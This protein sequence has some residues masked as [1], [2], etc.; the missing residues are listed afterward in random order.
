MRAIVLV[1][2]AWVTPARALVCPPGTHVE[3]EHHEVLDGDSYDEQSCRRA[4]STKDGPAEIVGKAAGSYYNGKRDGVWTWSSDHRVARTVEYR[5]GHAHGL[6][7]YF[8]PAGLRTEQWT[9]DADELT[10]RY[11]K[12]HPNGKLSI[13]GTYDHGVRDGSW[14]FWSASGK[15]LGESTLDHGTGVLT[16]WYAN[17]KREASGPLVANVEHGT[18]TY[19]YDNGVVAERVELVNGHRD[20]SYARWYR[21]G[22]RETVGAYA[23]DQWNGTITSWY[24]NGR[25]EAV[26]EYDHG[27]IVKARN[28]HP[29][30]HEL[31]AK[32]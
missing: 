23:N 11:R 15:L 13:E 28:W 14:K 16:T 10:G 9:L 7:T 17:G 5:D 22:G 4:D 27:Q 25:R 3:L 20:G 19:W 30:G 12:W 2:C 32:P 6:E 26:V 31:V 21:D 24:A 1:L 29:G 18:W 8:S